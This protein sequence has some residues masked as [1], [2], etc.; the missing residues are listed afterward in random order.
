MAQPTKKGQR[1]MVRN[2]KD[3]VFTVDGFLG[4]AKIK[5]HDNILDALKEKDG[6]EAGKI[7]VLWDVPGKDFQGSA[8]AKDCIII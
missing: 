1:V 6:F 4:A 2:D 5:I 8:W 7:A 3:L